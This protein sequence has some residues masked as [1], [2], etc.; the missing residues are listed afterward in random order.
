MKHTILGAWRRLAAWLAPRRSA[1]A[2]G[3][4]EATDWAHA[5]ALGEEDPG[6]AVE[7]LD[8]RPPPAGEGCTPP[9]AR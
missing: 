9:H 1:G 5:S 4:A 6:A 3:P 7:A 8:S 2:S